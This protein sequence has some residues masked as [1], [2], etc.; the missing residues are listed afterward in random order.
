MMFRNLI[1]R[2]I[3]LAY[4]T[5]TNFIFSAS[6]FILIM[7]LMPFVFGINI[8][9]LKFIFEGL[10]WIGITLALLLTLDSIFSSDF[11]DGN[12]DIILGLKMSFET[13]ALAKVISVWIINCLPIIFVMPIIGFIFGFSIDEILP[14][15]FNLFLGS[16]GMTA[17]A[18]MVSSLTLGLKRMIYLK[19]IIIIPLYIP[20]IIFGV[21]TGSWPIVLALSMISLVFLIFIVPYSLRLYGE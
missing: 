8:L 11:N 1:L 2:D 14:I 17:T 21:D 3:K 5:S 12:L 16:I 13:I 9:D 19:S 15:N 10:I 18:V 7:I 6:F 20:F 4:Y